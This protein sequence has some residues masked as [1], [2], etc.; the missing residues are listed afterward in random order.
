VCGPVIPKVNDEKKRYESSKDIEVGVSSLENA[1]ELLEPVI[2]DINTAIELPSDPT[3][4]SKAS[5][6]ISSYNAFYEKFIDT[7]HKLRT[8][9]DSNVIE[10]FSQSGELQAAR[11][12]FFGAVT[13][14]KGV[15]DR[16]GIKCPWVNT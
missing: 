11:D 8:Y 14:A 7:N 9:L 5:D 16:L 1:R 4:K 13:K 6:W 15:G 10:Q 2:K 3:E 12:E